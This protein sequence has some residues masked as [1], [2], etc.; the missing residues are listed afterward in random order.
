[1]QVS[2]TSGS[3]IDAGGG[4]FEILREPTAAD[5]RAPFTGKRSWTGKT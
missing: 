2:G 4:P 5:R 1:M 3:W